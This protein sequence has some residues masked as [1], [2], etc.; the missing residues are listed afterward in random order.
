MSSNYDL[1]DIV[2]NRI[3]SCENSFYLTGGTALNRFYVSTRISDDLDFFTSATPL[4]YEY[5][6]EIFLDIRSYLKIEKVVQ[7][8]DFQRFLAYTEEK[9]LQLDFVNDRVY[10][11]GKSNM[12]RHMRIDNLINIISNKLT[13]IMNREDAKD[14]V[15]LLSLCRNYS[16]NWSQL[17][18]IVN[19]KQSL[20]ISYLISKAFEFPASLLKEIKW[21]NRDTESEF[22]SSIEKDLSQICTEISA[23][24]INTLGESKCSLAKATPNLI[25]LE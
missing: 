22:T 7:E 25:N 13:A 19:K 14:I 4:F 24:T 15:D 11:E 12:Y 20:P 18:N 9:R 10:R 23:L 6:E 3:F 16:F 5:C 8:R 21:I 1:Q 17:I 2:L